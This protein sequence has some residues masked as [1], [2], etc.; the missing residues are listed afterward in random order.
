MLISIFSSL[1]ENGLTGNKLYIEWLK[2]CFKPTTRAKLQGEYQLLIINRHT[3]Y[4]FNKFIK[5]IKANKI[6]CLYLPFYLTH[7]LQPLNINIF[8]PLKQ[9][10]K[11]F[12]LKKPASQLTTLIKSISFFLFN[13][14]DDKLFHLK[15][16]NRLG[17]LRAW[18]LITQLLYFKIFQ[19]IFKILV[20]LL[21]F[22]IALICY[23][24][25]DILQVEYFSTLPISKSQWSWGVDV[26]F[27]K[28]NPWF[29]KAYYPS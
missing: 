12:Q 24:K 19:Y 4:V 22:I 29:T 5:F 10:Y 16:F 9:N 18:Y 2:N 1:S 14:L 13:K 15:I 20:P 25:P 8:G 28:P 23:Y 27:Q 21:L 17:V 11:S 6:I 7:L 3:S 26:T